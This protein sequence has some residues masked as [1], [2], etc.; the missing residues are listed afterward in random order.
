[1]YDFMNTDLIIKDISLACY[2]PVGA[3]TAVHNNR[4]D[5]GLAVNL[6]EEKTYRF[7]NG[8][9]VRVPANGIIFLP[10]GA[11]Y[12]V[13]AKR[14]GGCY[15]VNFS[16]AQDIA[17]EPFSMKMKNPPVF[18]ESFKQAENAWHTKK[19]GYPEKCKAELYAIIYNMKREYSVEDRPQDRSRVM[20]AITHIH[21]NYAVGKISVPKLAALCHLSE[22]VFRENFFAATG[23]TP[24]KYINHLRLS[25][26]AE[27]LSSNMYTVKEAMR[28]SGYEDE[29][30]FSRVFKL[31]FHVPPKEYKARYSKTEPADE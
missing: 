18:I 23:T 19:N 1:M 4:K 9:T 21:A 14:S 26:A 29:A 15:A 25:R 8:Q 13:K 7:E 12:V 6:E 24:I 5:Y 17:V 11:S 30:H 28:L 20:P 2:V 10:K 27:L 22:T 31:E 3:G 16:L